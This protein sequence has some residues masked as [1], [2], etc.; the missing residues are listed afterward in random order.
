MIVEQTLYRLISIRERWTVGNR[1]WQ[2]ISS[3]TLMAEITVLTGSGSLIEIENLT[4][5]FDD[6]TAVEGLTST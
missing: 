1:D 3:G 2:S 5:R 6:I 4:R